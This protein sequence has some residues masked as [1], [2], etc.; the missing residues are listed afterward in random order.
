MKYLK[1]GSSG[2]KVSQFCLGTW[3]MPRSSR[4]DEYGVRKVDTDELTRVIKTAF[5][6]GLNF[7]DTANRYHGAMAPVD[8]VHRGNSEEVLG[9]VLKGHERESF[10]IATKVGSE[11]TPW[12]N[13]KGLSRKH[14]MWQIGESLKRLQMDHVDVYLMHAPDP[15]TPHLETLKALDDLVRSGRVHYLGSSNHSQEEV[16]DFTQLASDHELHELVTLQEGYSLL[17]REIEK[18]MVPTAKRYGLS[19]MAY[20][21]LAEGMLSEKYLSGI[22]SQARASYSS[23]LRESI[24]EDRLKVIIELSDFAKSKG[25]SLPQL[26]LA[27][28]LKK[29]ATLDVT[30]VP[31]IGVSSTAQLLENLGAAEVK[32]SDEEMAAV[33]EIASKMPG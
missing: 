17:H 29:Q 10:V 12:E 7:I 4:T 24:T 18:T 9:D 32:L 15:E 28:I 26:A 19:I 5:D 3:H 2:L 14:I 22:P 33:E 8:I 13:G 31:I 1:L 11:M 6:S 21:P 27:W 30:I 25:A 16:A 23:K 20:S